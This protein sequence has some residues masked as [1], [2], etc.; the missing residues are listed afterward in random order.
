MKISI[1]TVVYNNKEYIK[2]AIESVLNQTYTNIEYI[3]VDGGSTDGTL[4]VIEQYINRIS[5]VIHGP[6]KGMYDALNKGLMAASGQVVGVLHSD[7]LFASNT[8]IEQVANAFEQY[9]CQFLYGN[10]QYVQKHDTTKVV[11]YWQS[12]TFEPQL[13]RKGFMPAHPTVFVNVL[14]IQQFEIY[15]NL[16]YKIAADYNWMVQLLKKQ[17]ILTYYLP[18]VITKMRVGGASNKNIKNIIKKS[19]EDYNVIRQNKIGGLYC[20]FMKNFGKI[21]QF[22]SK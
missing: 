4:D 18:I 6:D 7:D 14:L 9:K 20:L 19:W 3:V 17:N 10:L 2:S 5:K 13:L 16:N 1:I 8:I 22:F 12:K 11:R 15:Y 21:G